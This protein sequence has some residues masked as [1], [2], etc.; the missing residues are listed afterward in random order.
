MFGIY[1]HIPFCE[2]KCIYCDF[3][4]IERTEHIASFVD[5]LCNE[6]T[7]RA[8]HSE[9][10]PSATSV[11][12]GGG[13]PSLLS[14]EQLG[15]IITT[16]RRFYTIN[17]DAEWTMECNPGTITHT[18]LCGYRE[19]GINRL[20]FGVQSFNESELEFL[21]RIHSPHQ[22]EEA[23]VLARAAGFDNVNLDV[24]F[25]LPNQTMQSWQFTLN[26]VIALA[27][28]HI[29]AYS[30][31]F[32]EGTPLFTMLQRGVV[33]QAAEEHDALLYEYAIER[34]AAAGYQQYEVSNFAQKGR[35][36]IHNCTYWSGDE[37]IAFGPSAHGLVNGSRYWNFR[38]L[39]RY[40]ES[41]KD[42]KLPVANSEL[43]SRTE[44]MFERAFLE[45]RSRGIRIQEF[46][47]DFDI[48]I[49]LSLGKGVEL[50]HSEG[51]VEQS[52]GRLRLTAA[53]Y[54]VCDELSLRTIAALEKIAGTEWQ[55]RAFP[56][57]ERESDEFT[58]ALPVVG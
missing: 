23:I 49:I 42:G 56:E 55:E 41:I 34:L 37:Y 52:S 18:S 28:E 7:L 47:E 12:F 24:M 39:T 8:S 45:L 33:R 4:S 29:S 36:C 22:A 32:E 11:F 10:L 13:T 27:P 40:T 48:D 14:P 58:F 16:I 54:M 26:T 20:S 44:R 6:I 15:R 46:K 31:I 21:H 35:E 19:A 1:V 50:W 38:S 53:G 25:A 2:K 43:L 51:L 57:E 3:Y 5:T 30:L 9:L 17:T